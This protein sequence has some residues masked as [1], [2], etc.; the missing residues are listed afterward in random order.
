[1][2][3]YSTYLRTYQYAE[4]AAALANPIEKILVGVYSGSH[5]SRQSNSWSAYEEA[6]SCIKTG[7]HMNFPTYDDEHMVNDTYVY[8]YI[9]GA[10]EIVLVSWIVALYPYR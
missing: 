8:T 7:I 10:F 2:N 5:T 9:R 3:R 1:M 4:P 6:G